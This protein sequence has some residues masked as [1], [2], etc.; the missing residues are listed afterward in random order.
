INIVRV[1]YQRAF[2]VPASEDPA[3][4]ASAGDG[5]A[6]REV[7]V[8]HR[9]PQWAIDLLGEKVHE[10][11]GIIFRALGGADGSPVTGDITDETG[12]QVAEQRSEEHTSELQ[13]RENLVC[14][15][16]LEKKKNKRNNTISSSRDNSFN[17][18]IVN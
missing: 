12:A 14:R 3:G 15:L 6:T 5:I 7:V 4:Q 1:R 17:A 11:D 2:G 9:A 16:L 10:I 8:E 18:L 13:S